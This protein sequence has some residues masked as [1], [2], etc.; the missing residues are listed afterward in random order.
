MSEAIDRINQREM[1]EAKS[2][3]HYSQNGGFS[4]A[5]QAALGRVA[6]EVRGQRILDIGVGA[7]RTVEA[8]LRVSTDYLGVDI[9]PEMIAACRQRF[10]GVDFQLADA[11]ALE[12]VPTSSVKLA[13]FSCNGIGMVAHV[14]RLRILREVHRV[15]VQDGIFLFS[16]HNR[17]CSDHSVGLK[18]PPFEMTA[19]PVR[20]LVRMARF[21]WRTTLRA[22]RRFQHRKLEFHS[23]EYSMINDVCHDYGVMLYYISLE[24]QR[25]QLENAG[26]LRDAEAFDLNGEPVTSG[27]TDN[28]MMLVARK[29]PLHA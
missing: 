28:S 22:Y 5:E 2:V 27:T 6:D 25:R 29:A 10:P 14:D 7:G 8:L 19:N 4:A 3:L 21:L 18:L 1:R 11:R 20:M 24:N 17:D 23:S 16:T 15:L 13:V 26:F 12:G 9:S